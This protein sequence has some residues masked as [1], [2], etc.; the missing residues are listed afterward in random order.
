MKKLSHHKDE[1]GIFYELWR[2]DPPLKIQQVNISHSKKGVIRGIH[3]E[4]WDKYLHVIQG[5]ILA[6]IVNSKGTHY[7]TYELDN[8]KALH[9][10]AGKGNSFQALE[11]TIYCYLITGKW[12]KNKKY[13][14][15]P[16]NSLKIPWPIKEIIVSEKDL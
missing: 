3:F 15:L 4:P 12:K 13:K 2:G 16:Y 8:T 9:V 5:K 1:R 11:N 14:S 10:P 7:K 6:V